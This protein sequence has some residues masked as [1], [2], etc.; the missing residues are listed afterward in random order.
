VFVPRYQSDSYGNGAHEG[1]TTNSYRPSRPG[2]DRYLEKFGERTRVKRKGLHGI[3]TAVDEKDIDS[4]W[5]HRDKLAQ[6]ERRELAE[7]GLR[8]SRSSR[9]GSKV[10]Q[11]PSKILVESADLWEDT[12]EGQEEV[13]IDV[14]LEQVRSRRMSTDNV[15]EDIPNHNPIGQ[16]EWF[17]RQMAHA[18]YN[19]GYASRPSTSR[20]PVF[21]TNPVVGIGSPV[22]KHSPVH[23]SRK[24]SLGWAS[25]N[26]SSGNQMAGGGTGITG[27]QSVLNA[28][29][30]DAEWLEQTDRTSARPDQHSQT[31]RQ[32]L[33]QRVRGSPGRWTP[34]NS[35]VRKVSG[36]RG[37]SDARQRTIA[38]TG[39]D[40]PRRPTTSGDSRPA[41]ARPE[42]EA[43]WIATMYKPDPRLPPEEQMLPTHA[44]RLALE[45][46][47]HDSKPASP[48][49]P[50]QG[51]EFTPYNSED[52]G[53]QA[54]N[55][56][57]PDD[58]LPE[59]EEISNY[60]RLDQ[61]ESHRDPVRMR[62]DLQKSSRNIDILQTSD[63]GRN[64]QDSE[65]RQTGEWPLKTPPL[66]AHSLRPFSN[67]ASDA[68]SWRNGRI[69]A[70]G[71]EH[72][73]YSVM[74]TIQTQEEMEQRLSLRPG[75]PQDRLSTA[76]SQYIPPQTEPTR[77]L[78][79]P[80]PEKNDKTGCAKCCIVM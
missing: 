42:G 16:D 31:P 40:S 70:N 36:A 41:T 27:S 6:I 37:P 34:P 57:Q 17:T 77:I 43:P 45:Q 79:M 53:E 76:N 67:S 20:I 14:E 73:G 13:Q 38:V 55:Q 75:V 51:S 2:A 80:E 32:S 7:M 44:K 68:G 4:K 5:I 11:K 62:E 49:R 21:K 28:A 9:R 39:V 56:D 18:N 78:D 19:G 71:H 15:A 26:E 58:D 52:S 24:D 65:K 72:G 63:Y 61:S 69:S 8:L 64:L 66:S 48:S 23:R 29:A 3:V 74:P 33:E 10:G 54:E 46:Q 59:S 25:L 35:G 30:A 12:V 47:E 22:E 50:K 60:R 1:N